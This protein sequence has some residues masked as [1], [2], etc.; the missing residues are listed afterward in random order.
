M[1][2][3][4]TCVSLFSVSITGSFAQTKFQFVFTGTCYTTDSGGKI[5]PKAI[6]NK[7]LL[8]DYAAA[9]GVT[10]TSGLSLAYHVGGNDLGDMIDVINL[11]DGASVATIFGLYFGEDFGRM[12]LLSKSGK[13]MKRI[14]YVYTDQNSHSLGSVLLTDYYFFDSD[15]HTNNTLILG[16]M[17]YLI[18]PNAT[19]TNV[20]I[21]SGSF[22][23]TKPW[24]F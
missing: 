13:Q 19:H 16:Q 18:L 14:E 21:C 4:L 8:Q 3:I 22:T 12:G 20:Q 23:T 6:S 2:L 1:K 24:K 15:G 9:H 5:V 7:S 11:S 17:Q 10:N